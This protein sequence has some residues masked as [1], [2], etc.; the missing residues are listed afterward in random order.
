MNNGPHAATFNI[1]PL[2]FLLIFC[3]ERKKKENNPNQQ[4][5]DFVRYRCELYSFFKS[6]FDYSGIY[7]E[8][9]NSV[10][11]LLF[12]IPVLR[13]ISNHSLRLTFLLKAFYWCR[14]SQLFL[15]GKLLLIIHILLL[16]TL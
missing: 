11:I 10:K 13:N 3:K 1:F 15:I 7:W 9:H 2:N 16:Y 4:N 12:I 5:I 14:V 8:V 6:S